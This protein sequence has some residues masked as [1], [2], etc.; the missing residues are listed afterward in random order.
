MLT[1]LIINAFIEWAERHAKNANT[2]ITEEFKADL[3]SVIFTAEYIIR[4]DYDVTSLN[5]T[6][7][8]SYSVN[9][10]KFPSVMS[11]LAAY[12]KV[13]SSSDLVGLGRVKPLFNIRDN[14]SRTSLLG[15]Y[16]AQGIVPPDAKDVTLLSPG[17]VESIFS[18]L[19][20]RS[21]VFKLSALN[22]T[23]GI[24][25]NEIGCLINGDK[26]IYSKASVAEKDEL[27]VQLL[28]AK[29]DL[30]ATWFDR[31]SV[32][33]DEDIKELLYTSFGAK[34]SK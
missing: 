4:Q 5:I 28:E 18:D 8:R 3:K 33:D 22:R 15:E 2:L 7:S 14:V 6:A 27:A 9:D 19:E 17:K 32:Y 13:Y 31:K 26:F 12:S 11:D 25:F 30:N 16:V 24:G 1:K 29:C 10:Y 21:C 20:S 23:K 34:G